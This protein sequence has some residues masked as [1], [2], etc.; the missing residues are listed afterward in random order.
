MKVANK[1]EHA[2]DILIKI[3]SLMKSDGKFKTSLSTASPSTANTRLVSNVLAEYSNLWPKQMLDDVLETIMQLLPEGDDDVAVEPTIFANIVEAS[4]PKPSF[5]ASRLK[6]IAQNLLYRVRSRDI[7]AA[8]DAFDSLSAVAS[9]PQSP[10]FLSVERNQFSTA[11]NILLN[12]R[13]ENV[14]GEEVL[15]ESAEISSVKKLGKDANFFTGP[16]TT[17]GGRMTADLSEVSL[18]PGRYQLSVTVKVEDRSKSIAYD[19][20]FTIFGAYDIRG[21]RFG[22]TGSKKLNRDSLSDVEAEQGLLGVT[23][24]SAFKSENVH[25]Y[26]AVAAPFMTDKHRFIKPHQ[27]LVRYT[28][29]NS[30]SSKVFLG[31]W[32]GKLSDAVGGYYYSSIN[33]ADESG[34]F[35]HRSGDYLVSVIVGDFTAEPIEWV[36][37]TVYLEFNPEPKK[38][39]PLYVKSLLDASDKTLKPLPEIAHRM[40]PPAK[41]ASLIMST[42]FTV[43]S[44]MPLAAFL[45]FTTTMKLRLAKFL[46][47]FP[48]VLF[49]GCVATALLLYGGYWLGIPGLNFYDTIK[50]IAV[51][52]PLT[53][54]I[55]R[56]ALMALAGDK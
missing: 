23:K 17:E 3:K 15:V 11:D 54:I 35:D 14:L 38:D 26:F 9:L 45:Y 46:T 53:V 25:V 30:G 18:S 56:N 49:M 6:L 10:V 48:N 20:F 32:D 5:T 24:A 8:S 51:L 50:Y 2:K 31:A 36:L 40:R 43:F 41:R 16:M 34:G 42:L 33:L 28:E 55:G 44:L 12:L 1:A 19:E 22:I 4:E 27:V 7:S 39:S 21:V 29:V 52:T 47:S 37:G 13:C